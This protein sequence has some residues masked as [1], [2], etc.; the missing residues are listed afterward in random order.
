MKIIKLSRSNHQKVIL[1]AVKVLKADG[2]VIYPTETC[3]GAGVDATNQPAVD[4]LLTYKTRR[5]GKPLSI[6]VADKSMASNYVK[7]NTSALNSSADVNGLF[8]FEYE[9]S[10]K[11]RK[12]VSVCG[13][14]CYKM[15][16]LDGTWDNIT[17]SISIT[18]G[19][20]VDGV[21]FQNRQYMIYLR[22]N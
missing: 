14:K 2:L 4:K 15:D 6:A 18:T 12:A 11:Q 7:L 17:S 20:H 13:D 21:P 5:E 19:Y 22:H 16:D 8:W 10:G 9:K 1:E 3:Y